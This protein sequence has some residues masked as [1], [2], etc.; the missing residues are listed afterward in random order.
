[1]F[2]TVTVAAL[3]PALT[4]VPLMTVAVVLVGVYL[5][6]QLVASFVKVTPIVPVTDVKAPVEV[7]V[8][9]PPA[10]DPGLGIVPLVCRRR[11]RAPARPRFRRSRPSSPG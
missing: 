3:L 11:R 6:G 8:W 4:A 10:F 7:N 9:A 1:V 5:S 2:G